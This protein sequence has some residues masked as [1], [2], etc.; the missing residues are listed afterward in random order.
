MNLQTYPEIMTV[1]EVAEYLRTSE[2][3]VLN[4]TNDG[5]LPGGKMGSVW[6][7][8]RDDINR[9]VNEQLRNRPSHEIRSLQDVITPDAVAVLKETSKADV[10]NRLVEKMS[11]MPMIKNPELLA[12][13]IHRRE[14]MMS[15]AIGL[16]L[17]VP[18]VRLTSV[19]DLAVCVGLSKGIE[20]YEAIDGQPVRLIVMIAAREDQ[21]AEHLRVVSLVSQRMRDDDA[22]ARILSSSTD[23]E[24]FDNLV[25]A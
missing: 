15:T 25:S 21:H 24:L 11:K 12:E 23:R 19:S 5:N 13:A 2:R 17:G 9:W 14:G 10:L 7:F 16:Q 22:R 6:R 18:H 1:E 8:R 20:D 3:T 4:W